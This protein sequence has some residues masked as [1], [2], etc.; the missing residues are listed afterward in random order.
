MK[1]LLLAASAVIAVAMSA[2]AGAADMR[3]PMKA[4][5]PPPPVFNWTGCYIGAGGGYGMWNQEFVHVTDPGGVALTL[6]QTNG[7][8][9][10]FGTVQAGCDYQITPSIVIGAFA[11]YDF[12]N[13]KGDSNFLLVTV[14]EEKLRRSWAVGGRIGWVALPQL[15]TFVSAGYTQARFNQV[16]LNVLVLP[17]PP[18][19]IALAEQTYDGWF[20]G[21]GYEYSIGW[22]PGL[23]WKTE[24][25]FADYGS[26]RVPFVI[27]ATGALTGLAIDAN[28]YVHTVRSELVWRFNWG[29]GR[30]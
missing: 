21:T 24:Y 11:D 20:L 13:I 22:L 17:A 28:K 5:P 14:G 3:V 15:L 19:G 12:S 26:E 30:Y 27:T 29:A 8:R 7:G 18:T 10:W 23:F 6:E 9:G 25:R 4:P 1:K 16:D 2:P